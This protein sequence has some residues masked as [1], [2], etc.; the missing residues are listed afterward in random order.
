MNLVAVVASV[1]VGAAFVVAGGSKIAAGPDWP[2]QARNLGAPAFVIPVVP[3][4]EIAL[5]AI[6]IVQFG[7]RTAAAAALV[8]LAAFTGLI[9]LRLAEGKRPPCSCF[10]AWSSKPLGF[11]H[12]VRNVALIA[13][14][15]LSLW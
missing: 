12:V 3:W 10:G 2:T 11:G 6:L 14:A 13:L 4:I 15:T 7:R 8:V 1:L 5:G 9:L